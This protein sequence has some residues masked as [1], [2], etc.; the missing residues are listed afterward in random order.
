MAC[1]SRYRLL[2]LPW[3]KRSLIIKPELFQQFPIRYGKLP[4][5]SQWI[6]IVQLSFKVTL[7]EIIGEADSMTKTLYAAAHVA[8]ILKIFKT[9]QAHSS[10]W[11]FNASQVPVLYSFH[12]VAFFLMKL[13]IILLTLCTAIRH[14]HASTMNAKWLNLKAVLTLSNNLHVFIIFG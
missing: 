8:R 4:F 11:A 7:K 5:R 3:C 1:K 12:R 14:T 2:K 9:C 6:F 13:R 10:I